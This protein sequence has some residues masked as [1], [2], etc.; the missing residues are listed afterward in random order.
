MT[1]A[2]VAA[3]PDKTPDRLAQA[4]KMI[5]ELHSLG[6][7]DSFALGRELT[8]LTDW[9]DADSSC[10]AVVV[11]DKFGAPYA[12]MSR[13]T[14]AYALSRPFVSELYKHRPVEEI[15]EEWGVP[16]L[17]IPCA[18]P[19]DSAVTS[20]LA[21]PAPYRYEPLLVQG[22]GTWFL[23]EIHDLL[24]QQC[25]LLSAT[26]DEVNTKRRELIAAQQES[27]RLHEQFV[28]ASRDAGR[29]EVATGVLHNVGNVLNSV[30][31]SAALIARTLQD[32]KLSNLGKALTLIRE[33]ENDLFAFLTSEERGKRLP[34]YLS[35]L[36]E[37]LVAEQ[38]TVVE[39]LQLMERSIEHI[40]QIVQMQQSYA[41]S[42]IILEPIRPADIMEDALRVNLV[43]FDRHNIKLQPEYQDIGPVSID[44]HKV[45]QILINLIS[46]AKNSIKQNH[47]EERRIITRIMSLEIDGTRTVR[48]QIID[49]GVGITPENLTKIFS[50]G[51]TTRKD[52][53]GFGLHSSAN[54]AREMGGSLSVF[55][56][57][58]GIGAVFTLDIPI[59]EKQTL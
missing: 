55:S 33:H 27:E 53:H 30:N 20:A 17:A 46:N 2:N 29:A 58:P 48:F 12:I 8:E 14:L 42:A 40:R 47:P 56:D 3:S 5:G 4:S 59:K 32:S 16:V 39:E 54:A 7:Q 9:F 18:E 6:R 25:E 41:R 13:D 23:L 22:E 24:A 1:C 45:L 35:K 38:M 51:F 11:L 31:V 57:G 28:T 34:G 26:I 44:R 10:F 43:S 21:R 15:L 50:N 49:N 37:V 19:I 52:G 36:G